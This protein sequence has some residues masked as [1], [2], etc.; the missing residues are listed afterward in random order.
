MGI[1]RASLAL[2]SECAGR[3]AFA[4]LGSRARRRRYDIDADDE[5]PVEALG[6]ARAVSPSL[7][8][9]AAALYASTVL[10][11]QAKCLASSLL[12]RFDQRAN[13]AGSRP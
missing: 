13:L 9:H 4:A 1:S 3:C 5:R 7:A 11:I 10:T 6:L 12:K 2:F 8:H